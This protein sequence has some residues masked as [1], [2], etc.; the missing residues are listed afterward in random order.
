MALGA[1]AEPAVS[2][3]ISDGNRQRERPQA[4]QQAESSMRKILVMIPAGEV[5]DHDCVRWYKA[6]D[7]QRCIDQYHNIGDAF[8]HD[9]SLKLLD[10]DQVSVLE[11]R[12]AQQAAIDRYNAEYDF[13]FLR[14]SNYLNPSMDWSS[15]LS[16]LKKLK[17]PVIAFG[18]GAQ[19]PSSGPL[20]LSEETKEV[21]RAIADHSTTLGVRG[22]YTADLLWSI[23]VK[24]VRVIG[25]PTLFRRNDA[26]LRID[27]P[28]LADVH[29]VGY[30][31]RR[32]VSP[33][34]A[35][36]IGRY[37]SIQRQTILDMAARFEVTVMAQGEVEEKK[38]VFGTAEQRGEA[39]ESL[40]KAEWFAG[41]DDPVLALYLSRL[42]YS[43][44]VADYDSIVR[45]QDLV[46]GYRLHGNLIALANR[47][48]AVYFTY[49]S[50]TAEF[51]ETFQIPAFDVFAGQP[52]DLEAYWDQNRFERFNRAAYAGY[53]NMRAFL[54][55]NAIA[56][57]MTG[58]MPERKFLNVA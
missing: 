5:Y 2:G 51:V 24:N 47:V 23:G 57:R 16:V 44:V 22:T 18:I 39:I 8:V 3:A 15:A 38:M 21:M 10:Y 26:N 48:P 56:N 33:T 42:F 34:Y 35:C 36:D 50:R 6:H 29:R 43:D 30:T 32:E 53:R 28:P 41:A 14:G 40:K 19:A 17:I 58:D 12:S 1:S 31:L 45:A 7:T 9:S 27:L 11:I 20:I 55:E 49:D 37:L 13:C 4:R 54:Q 25:C 46:L 52:F